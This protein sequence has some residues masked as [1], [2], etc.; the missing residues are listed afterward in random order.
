MIK[1]LDLVALT[2]GLPEK[3]LEAGDI[4]TVVMV[5]EGGRGYTVEFMTLT[6]KTLAIATMDAAAVRPLREHEIANAR[7]VA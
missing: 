6:G 7:A 3:N 2:R 5:H 1:D 4:G